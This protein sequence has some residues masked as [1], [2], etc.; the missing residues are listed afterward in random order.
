M[1]FRHLSLGMTRIL[2][3]TLV[4]SSYMIKSP[5]KIYTYSYTYSTFRT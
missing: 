2:L 5:I 4:L 1:T 3:T